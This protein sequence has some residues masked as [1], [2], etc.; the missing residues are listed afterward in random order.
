MAGVALAANWPDLLESEIRTV[1]IDRYKDLPAMV[2]DVFNVIT[3]D[4][5]YEKSTQVGAVPDHVEFTGKTTLVER[6]QGYDKTFTFT[7]YTAMILIQRKLMADDQSRTINKFPNGLAE[8]ANRSR[9]KLGA[10][11]FN[12]AWTYEPSD[13]DG[14][15][16]AASDHPSNVSGV[17]TQSNEGTSA[18]SAANVE[19]TRLLM[20]DFTNDIGETITVNPDTLLIPR[21][22]E[23]TG[24]EIINSKGKVDTADNNANFHQ[25]KYKLIVWD[26]LSDVNNWFMADYTRMKQDNIWWNR[27]PIQLNK[28]NDSDTMAAKYLSYYRCGVGWEDWLSLFGQL[29]S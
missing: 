15:E 1:Y 21:D 8:S 3:S 14:C 22:L 2:P 19:A 18:L 27:E 25:G 16:W 26:R 11:Q 5:P 28:D 24:W 12:L 10:N 20:Y 17:S 13:G 7:E 6:T 29:V 4:R 9:E 23:E